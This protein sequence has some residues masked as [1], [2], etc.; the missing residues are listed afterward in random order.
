MPPVNVK[1]VSWSASD[2]PL[3]FPPHWL[4]LYEYHHHYHHHHPPNKCFSRWNPAGDDKE[5]IVG[6]GSR[7]DIRGSKLYRKRGVERPP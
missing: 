5:V 2:F 3:L 6:V 7:R 1:R 4:L